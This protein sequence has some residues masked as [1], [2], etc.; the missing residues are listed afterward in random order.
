MPPFELVSEGIQTEKGLIILGIALGRKHWLDQS[1]ISQPP[2][3]TSFM[4]RSPA[5]PL[6][7]FLPTSLPIEEQRYRRPSEVPAPE[8]LLFF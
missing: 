4:T 6:L 2:G 8:K 1:E 3:T 7:F 5:V